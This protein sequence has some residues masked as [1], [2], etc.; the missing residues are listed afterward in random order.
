MS[1][2]ECFQAGGCCGA[3]QASSW[4]LTLVKWALSLFLCQEN[5]REL[6][7]LWV[8]TLPRKSGTNLFCFPVCAFPTQ[9]SD[10]PLLFFQHILSFFIFSFKVKT[11]ACS[12]F[13]FFIPKQLL[14]MSLVAIQ[15]VPKSRNF[16]MSPEKIPKQKDQAGRPTG[17]GYNS[18]ETYRGRGGVTQTKIHSWQWRTSS[19]TCMHG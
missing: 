3:S 13:C 11:R 8:N 19:T 9:T 12:L 7:I 17:R 6:K 16:A 14:F 4:E 5:V 15:K 2:R 18:K 10:F 1:N